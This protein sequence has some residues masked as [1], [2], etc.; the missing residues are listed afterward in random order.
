MYLQT[1]I[2]LRRE[3]VVQTF[4]QIL[5]HSHPFFLLFW[6]AHFEERIWFARKIGVESVRRIALLL[7]EHSDSR[8]RGVIGIDGANGLVV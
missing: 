1:E 5:H 6:P 3:H 7:T 2:D 8:F 4:C